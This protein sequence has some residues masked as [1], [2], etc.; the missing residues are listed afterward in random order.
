MLITAYRKFGDM[1]QG[2]TSHIH[3]TEACALKEE[4]VTGQRWKN[5]I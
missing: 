4:H 5:M 3:K 1:C 2:Y